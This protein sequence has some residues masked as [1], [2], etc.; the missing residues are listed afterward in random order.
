MGLSSQLGP[1]NYGSIQRLMEFIM[2]KLF[3]FS[4]LYM[5]SFGHMCEK[6]F[7]KTMKKAVGMGSYL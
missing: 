6:E 1:V 5:K 2:L 4:I 7:P 3:N